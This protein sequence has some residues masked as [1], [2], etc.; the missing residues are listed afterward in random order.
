MKFPKT[1]VIGGIRWKI[2]VDRKLKGGGEFY[3]K[4]HT[5]RI[6]SCYDDERRFHTLIH[7]IV[8]A[9]LVNNNLR[10]QKGFTRVG[11]G[12]Y[13]YSFNHDQFETFTDELAGVLMQIYG[14]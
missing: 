11:N 12:D 8:E 14:R 4:E 5:I 9:I 6:A 13:L 7:E 10:F 1:L 2:I 3:W